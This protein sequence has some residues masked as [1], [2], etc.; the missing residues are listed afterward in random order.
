MKNQK[1]KE[2]IS[3]Y[4]LFSLCPRKI[5]G[6]STTPIFDQWESKLVAGTI[7]IRESVRHKDDETWRTIRD[8]SWTNFGTKR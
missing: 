7:F 3:W 2:N 8:L 1:S 5:G 6:G 4:S